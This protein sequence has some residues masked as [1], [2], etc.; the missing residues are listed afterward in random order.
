MAA[1]ST[2]SEQTAMPKE[3]LL[4]QIVASDLSRIALR[5][6]AVIGDSGRSMTLTADADLSQFLIASSAKWYVPKTPFLI[7]TSQITTREQDSLPLYFDSLVYLSMTVRLTTPGT[8]AE[9]DSCILSGGEGARFAASIHRIDDTTVTIDYSAVRSEKVFS[10]TAKT[11]YLE[12][13]RRY[14]TA[15]TGMFVITE[16][17]E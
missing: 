12:F 7:V 2:M 13:C 11:D 8:R 1:R 3:Q 10:G 4:S 5:R 14:L 6:F 15:R 16:G 17:V 9:A